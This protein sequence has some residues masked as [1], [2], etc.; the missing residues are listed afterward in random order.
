MHAQI[1]W[2]FLV[3]SVVSPGNLLTGQTLINSTLDSKPSWLYYFNTSAVSFKDNPYSNVPDNN[4]LSVDPQ[5]HV[6]AFFE[7]T[8]GSTTGPINISSGSTLQVSF[9]LYFTATLNTAG[10][11]SLRFGLFDSNGASKPTNN[12]SFHPYD[13]YLVAWNPGNLNAVRFW[14]R[15]AP[16]TGSQQLM[17]STSVYT[18]EGS[19]VDSPYVFLPGTSYRA[20]YS[21]TGGT[22]GTLT[23]ALTINEGST[24]RFSNSVSVPTPTTSVFDTF[25]LYAVSGGPYLGIDNLLIT[26]TAAAPSNSSSGVNS[27]DLG[28][29]AI[30]EPSTYAACAGAAVLGLAFWRRRRAAAKALA[31]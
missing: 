30:P 19:D 3:A 13:G 23:F 28:G 18:Q 11:G 15:N 6:V 25:A 29:G 27:F 1:R 7:Q 26:L 20:N 24:L 16:T 12:S 31:A 17:N 21:V 9:D 22:G 2:L 8:T 4:Y 10:T 5:Q 14:K